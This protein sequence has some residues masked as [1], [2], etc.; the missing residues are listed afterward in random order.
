LLLSKNVL[1]QSTV[2]DAD[3]LNFA[4]NL[5][6]LEAQFYTLATTGK[7]IDQVGVGIGAGTSTSGGGTVTV[8]ASPMVSFT[9]PQLQQYAMETAMDEQ[10][11]VTFLRTALGANAVAQPNI[12]LQNS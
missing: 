12:D 2:T 8:K 1:A 3:I 7:T 4:L 5:E 6:Y 11:H 10:N 9:T